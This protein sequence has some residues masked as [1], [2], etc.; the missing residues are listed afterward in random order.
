MARGGGGEDERWSSMGAGGEGVG[1]DMRRS[2]GG[3]EGMEGEEG[4]CGRGREGR[5]DK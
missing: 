1:E 4:G 2:Q 5:R 3:E